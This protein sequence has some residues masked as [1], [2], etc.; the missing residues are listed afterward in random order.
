MMVAAGAA[1]AVRAT[2]TIVTVHGGSMEPTFWDGDRVLAVRWSG[3]WHR[4]CGSAVVAEVRVPGLESA[5]KVVMKRLM[6]V[7][8]DRCWLE[9]DSAHSLDSRQLGWIPV[10]GLRALVIIRLRSAGG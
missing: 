4:M 10:T 3:R 5:P 7:C 2:F 6:Q 1:I 9:G 8:G